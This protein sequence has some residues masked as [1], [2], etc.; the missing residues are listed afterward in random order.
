VELVAGSAPSS[1]VCWVVG[2]SGVVLL[3]IDG[4]T[5]WRRVSFPEATDLRSVEATDSRVAT[6]TAGDG[7][8]FRTTDGGVSWQR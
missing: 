8:T 1:G 3:T 4:G 5:T 2:G 7:R 6:I